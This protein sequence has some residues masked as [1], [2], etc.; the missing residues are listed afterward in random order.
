[1]KKI[2]IVVGT[3]PNFIKVTQFK[4]I[5][6]AQ[7]EQKIEIKIVHTGQH[8]DKLMS[9]VFF[10]QFGLVPDYFLNI[11]TQTDVNTQF[12]AIIT[13]VSQTIA[14]YS[15]HLVVVVGDVNSTLAAAL[16][17]HHLHLPMAHLESGLRSHD[18]AMPEELNRV[19][20]DSLA[21]YFFVTEPSGTQNLVAEGKPQDRIFFVGNTMID[22]MVAYKTQ[23]AQA[24]ILPKLGIKPAQDFALMTMHRPSNV[25]TLEGLN[26]ILEL[27]A[28][29]TAQLSVVFSVHPRTLSNLQ[30]HGLYHAITQNPNL[31]VCPPLDYFAFQHLV[32]NCKFVLTDSGGIQEEASFVQKPCLTFRQNTERPCTITEGSNQLMPFDLDLIKLKLAELN[33]PSKPKNYTIPQLW[34]GSATERILQILDKTTFEKRL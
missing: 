24:D 25:D 27:I 33:D 9:D 18:R 19:L 15:P 6:L 21:D 10:E 13:G 7:Y 30:K 4:R 3:R 17:A 22:T 23:I 34:D 20:T 31:I 11:A 14:E 16:A 8:Y 5:A 26:K 32:A 28:L 1:M 2:L 29:A 12:S